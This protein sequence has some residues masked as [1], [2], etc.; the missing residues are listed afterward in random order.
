MLI[1]LEPSSFHR[2][3]SG[4]ISG[5][6]YL[7]LDGFEFPDRG[8]NDMPIALLERWVDEFRKL[9][10]GLTASVECHF[11]DGPFLFRLERQGNQVR[12]RCFRNAKRLEQEG[13]NF[14][15]TLQMFEAG[16]VVA[17]REV[18]DACRKRGWT[19]E[20]LDRLARAIDH[21]SPVV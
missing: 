9:S 7:G 20:E 17:V 5:V 13:E 14:V 10:R 11:M 6:I 2:T 12:V 16:L 15:T 3:A 19:S 18:L 8:W 1:K 4:V 21:L